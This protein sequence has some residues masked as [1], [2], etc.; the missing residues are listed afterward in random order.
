MSNT[1]KA[2]IDRKCKECIYDAIGGAGTWRQQVEACT[3]VTCPLHP[4][5]PISRQKRGKRD[6]RI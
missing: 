6:D 4:V 3:A 2:C 1:R 5:R